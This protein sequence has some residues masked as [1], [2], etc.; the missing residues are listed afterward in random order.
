ME[1][2]TFDGQNGPRKCATFTFATSEK[3][4]DRSGNM[5]ENTEWHNIVAWNHAEFCE[6]YVTKGCLLY[7]EGKL[8]TRTWEDKQG[9]KRYTTEILEDKVDL[10]SRPDEQKQQSQQTQQP[11]Q[12][13]TP[14]YQQT[15][16]IPPAGEPQDDDLP[17]A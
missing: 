4:K 14:L 9:N 8:R 1:V 13:R 5:V 10:L 12:K 15:T 16:P 17:F 11:Q 7:I 3:Y 6:K 2:K